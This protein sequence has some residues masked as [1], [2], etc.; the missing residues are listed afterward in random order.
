M[1]RGASHNAVLLSHE[2]DGAGLSPVQETKY[3]ASREFWC[4]LNFIG[5]RTK[6]SKPFPTLIFCV[7]TLVAEKTH[8]GIFN[9]QK[10]ALAVLS[11]NPGGIMCQR[12]SGWHHV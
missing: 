3:F 1:R 5:Y 4:A 2:S 8:S 9:P 6:L 7:A 10:S 12:E 11:R